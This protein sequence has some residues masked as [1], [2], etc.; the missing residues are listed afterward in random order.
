MRKIFFVVFILILISVIYFCTYKKSTILFSIG[1]L[2]GDISYV[3]EYTRITDII[4]DIENNINVDGN[5]IQNLLVK[6]F[7]I[8]LDLTNYVKFENY[9][10]VITGMND[11]EDLIINIK[12]YTK[13]KIMINLL[14]EKNILYE[15]A[16]KKILLLAKK[17]GIMILR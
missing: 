9:N 14:E 7:R 6:A 12:K 15:Y 5:K 10:D 11:V 1:N 8:E 3:P 13:E 4:I 17:Y 2:N 16:N